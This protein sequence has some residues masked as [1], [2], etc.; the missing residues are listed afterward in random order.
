MSAAMK[1]STTALNYLSLKGIPIDR[2]DTCSLRSGG[3]NA[4]SLAGYS[5]RYIKKWGDGEEEL[6]R[7]I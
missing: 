7:N 6:L 1:F 3:D 5:N 4:L 2:V